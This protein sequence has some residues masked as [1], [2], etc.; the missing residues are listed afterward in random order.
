M[1]AAGAGLREGTNIARTAL[2]GICAGLGSKGTSRE[3]HRCLALPGVLGVDRRDGW[4][5]DGVEA[6][7]SVT[8]CRAVRT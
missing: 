4:V 2:L 3:Y 6:V 8:T 5:W 1:P 7:A